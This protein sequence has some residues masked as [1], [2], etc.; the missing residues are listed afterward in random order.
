MLKVRNL[1]KK[2]FEDTEFQLEED[3]SNENILLKAK[4]NNQIRE[5]V[6]AS[7]G[8]NG[9]LIWE[10]IPKDWGFNT[11]HI[12]NKEHAYGAHCINVYY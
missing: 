11:T 10:G 3:E 5:I 9:M 8:S 2:E 7:I 1:I 6:I 4:A 12:K